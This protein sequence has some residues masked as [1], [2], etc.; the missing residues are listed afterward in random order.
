MIPRSSNLDPLKNST[1][2][3]ARL[4]TYGLSYQHTVDWLERQIHIGL[5]DRLPLMGSYNRKLIVSIAE[6]VSEFE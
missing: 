2:I 1:D 4:T 5:N 3:S 6:S